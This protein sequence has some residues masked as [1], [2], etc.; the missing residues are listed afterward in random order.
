[1]NDDN[2]GEV[3]RKAMPA[4]PPQSHM[5]LDRIVADGYRIRR[6][7]R[8]VI[9]ATTAAGVS[10]LAAVTA[11]AFTLNAPE[12]QGPQAADGFEAD[13][14]LVMS[15][16]SEEGWYQTEAAAIEAQELTE[17]AKSE[18]GDLLVEAGYVE[19]GDLDYSPP[20]DADVRDEMERSGSYAAALS[21]L[22]YHDL[23]LLFSP[24]EF[25]AGNE[26][27]V[28]LRGHFAWAADE[29]D[30]TSPDFKFDAMAPGG[31]TAE[32]G[33]EDEFAFPQPMI[34]ED[35]SG[36]SVEDLDDGRRLMVAGDGCMLHIAVAYPNGSGLRSSWDT[37]C[38]GQGYQV[39]V[40][41]LK[42]AML[43]MP[44]IDYDTSALV[45]YEGPEDGSGRPADDNWAAGADGDAVTTAGQVEDAMTGFSEATVIEESIG[46]VELQPSDGEGSTPLYQYSMAASLPITSY[47][48]GGDGP[49]SVADGETH[50]NLTYTLPGDWE[51][52]TS[53][54]GGDAG[55]V[56]PDCDGKA[57]TGCEEIEVGGRTAVLDSN[58]EAGIYDVT[59]FD[60][61][62]WAVQLFLTFDTA[63]GFELSEQ[64]FTE[65]AAAMPAPVY[66]VDALPAGE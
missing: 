39:T 55:R 19:A 15:A 50:V 25:S 33:P 32:P 9:G 28:Y 53:E 3:F 38:E 8:T 49:G 54:T 27:E 14:D 2:P 52:W 47:E 17:A 10:V 34:V 23:P 21:E 31:W 5:D 61:S 16:Y 51:Q 20:T 40:E 56:L 22:G 46:A 41:E 60:E 37:G 11:L 13:Q 29:E 62:G 66:D 63:V 18:F 1:M 44:E 35:G 43:A 12:G 30:D 26:G 36:V 6:R 42:A 4:A 59:V 24:R 45:P 64:E 57:G 7:N 48:G 65:M 58:P